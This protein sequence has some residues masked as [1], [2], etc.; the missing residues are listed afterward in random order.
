MDLL[1]ALLNLSP[2]QGF[3][4]VAGVAVFFQVFSGS[5]TTDEEEYDDSFETASWN[6]ASVNYND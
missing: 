3:V 4:A 6:P 5:S 1:N 2:A